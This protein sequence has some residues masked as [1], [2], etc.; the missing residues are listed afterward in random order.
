MS[1]ERQRHRFHTVDGSESDRWR[2]DAAFQQPDGNTTIATLNSLSVVASKVIPMFDVEKMG[3]RW[4]VVQD[5]CSQLEPLRSCT[6]P[7]DHLIFA[8]RHRVMCQPFEKVKRMT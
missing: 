4:V 2:K 5:S 3:N 1:S 8:V 6:S 7:H